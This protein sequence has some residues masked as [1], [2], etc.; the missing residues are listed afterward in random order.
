MQVLEVS[1]Q[2]VPEEE[3]PQGLAAGR[4]EHQGELRTALLPD[5][6]GRRGGGGRL[7]FPSLLINHQRD[8]CLVCSFFY[9]DSFDSRTELRLFQV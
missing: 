1:D 2:E 5:Q 6:P 4:G 9:F 3:Q 8:K 7:N